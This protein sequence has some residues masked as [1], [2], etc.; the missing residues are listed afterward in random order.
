MRDL[1]TNTTE[2]TRNSFRLKAAWYV[3]GIDSEAPLIVDR[4]FHSS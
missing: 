4:L 2:E 3:P 1:L